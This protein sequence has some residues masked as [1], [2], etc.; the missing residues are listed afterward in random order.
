MGTNCILCPGILGT[1]HSFSS[2]LGSSLSSVSQNDKAG[3]RSDQRT[4]RFM[5]KHQ[6]MHVFHDLETILVAQSPTLVT[7]NKICA[8]MIKVEMGT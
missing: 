4:A 2:S 8:E 3:K 6:P 1:N 7:S 5:F